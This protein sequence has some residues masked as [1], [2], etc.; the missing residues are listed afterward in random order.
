MSKSSIIRL[1]LWGL[2]ALIPAGIL[3]P[4]SLLSLAV[5]QPAFDL[6]D[7]YGR[8]MLVLVVLGAVCATVSLVIE[9]IAWAA[10]VQNTSRLRESRWPTALLWGGLAGIA[11]VPL[12]GIGAFVFVCT[13]IAYL[14]AG[15]DGL[16]PQ[17]RTTPP[18]KH[19]VT[20]ALVAAW[21]FAAPG[22]LAAVLSGVLRGNN[23][24]GTRAEWLWVAFQ[25]TGIAVA[26]VGAVILIAAWWGA[27]FNASLLPDRTWFSSLRLTGII[28]VI[29]MPL[30]GISAVILTAVLVPYAIMA[31]DGTAAATEH[32]VPA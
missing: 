22:L 32:P 23:L 10:A 17:A 18:S 8:T 30:F 4:A 20:T 7:G 16:N 28:S 24:A 21:S 19:A 2:A 13:L 26:F 3:I 31:P 6:S 29:T 5:R 14:V 15:P 12:F 27:I 1:S 25:S 11:T 9:L